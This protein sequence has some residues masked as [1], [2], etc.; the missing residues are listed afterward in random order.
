MKTKEFHTLQKYFRT[1][2]AVT[3]KVVLLV[4]GGMD[5]LVTTAITAA[6]GLDL[7]AMHVNY[8]QRTWQR[9]LECFRLICNHY[10]IAERLEID[11]GYFAAIGGSS[12]TDLSML[13]GG[14]DLQGTTIPASYVPFRNAGFLSMAVSWAEVIGAERI[15][16]GAVEEDSSGYP[17]CRQVFYDAFNK[18]VE[19]GTRPETRIL[20]QT[21]LIAMQ[22]SEIVLKGMEL[23]APFEYSWSCY[24]S[25]GK[26]CGLCDSC[27][28][29]L[30]AFEL[31]GLRDPIDYEERPKYI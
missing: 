18:V 21:P 25:E 11:A 27:A 13:V 12:L 9:E 24:K 7:A 10:G 14:A 22:K 29:R 16:I 3:M 26:A 2:S 5:S 20:I 19:L 31:T 4:S 23:D 17:D 30:R 1:E 6:A 28:R 8:G 15:C